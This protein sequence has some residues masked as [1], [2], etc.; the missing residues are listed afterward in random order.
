MSLP[1]LSSDQPAFAA[2]F[3]GQLA[4]LAQCSMWH[5]HPA[6]LAWTWRSQALSPPQKW[7]KR[8]KTEKEKERKEIALGVTVESLRDHSGLILSK[9]I[10]IFRYGL[11]ETSNPNR[12]AQRRCPSGGFGSLSVEKGLK[13][14][15]DP[16]TRLLTFLLR[17]G[18]PHPAHA[19]YGCKEEVNTYTASCTRV[20]A[21]EDWTSCSA[22][23][24]TAQNTA[25]TTTRMHHVMAALATYPNERAKFGPKQDQSLEASLGLLEGAWAWPEQARVLL[26]C[27]HHSTLCTPTLHSWKKKLTWRLVHRRGVRIPSP[28]RIVMK[29]IPWE[30]LFDIL[31]VLCT[32]NVAMRNKDSSKECR[33]RFRN[34]N[35]SNFKKRKV[36]VIICVRR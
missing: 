34:F 22:T 7:E 31:D 26:C 27:C 35:Y 25:N 10:W 14:V 36:K 28:H 30:W 20:E 5:Q 16:A 6:S 23:Q 12:I 17:P 32:L 29:I 4:W 13:T 9:M 11:A 18:T 24:Q 2:G 21:A 15:L 8:E 19:W 33:V 3:L 1:A